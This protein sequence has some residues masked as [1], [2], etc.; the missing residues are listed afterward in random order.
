[1]TAL[2]KLSYLPYFRFLASS[3]CK[4][5]ASNKNSE[6]IPLLRAIIG[7]GLYPNMAHLR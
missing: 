2:C 6:K 1:M 7:A 5:A 4:D 3:N